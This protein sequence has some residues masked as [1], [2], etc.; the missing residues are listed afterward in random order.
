VIGNGIVSLNLSNPEGYIIGLYYDGTQNI[1]D[2]KNEQFDRGYVYIL[3]LFT[4]NK[5]H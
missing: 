4:L 5:L 2:N 1:L 3:H